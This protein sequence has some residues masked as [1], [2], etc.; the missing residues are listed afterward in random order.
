MTIY[1]I[2]HSVKG[3]NDNSKIYIE[4]STGDTFCSTINYLFANYS[5]L[6]IKVCD[7]FRFDRKNDCLVCYISKFY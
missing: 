2:I 4:D 5:Q 3:L 7:K 1:S 6:T